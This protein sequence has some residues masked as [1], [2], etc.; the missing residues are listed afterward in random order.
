MAVGLGHLLNIPEARM[1]VLLRRISAEQFAQR[2]VLKS[3]NEMPIVTAQDGDIDYVCP[4]CGRVLL[5]GFDA[6]THGQ[7]QQL[8][9]ECACGARLSSP[10]D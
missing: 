6:S 2:A 3:P 9:L 8:A 7:L 5:C 1:Q 4:N 10:E